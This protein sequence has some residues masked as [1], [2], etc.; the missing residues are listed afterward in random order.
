MYPIGLAS[1]GELG[2]YWE[3]PKSSLG[4]W[5]REREKKEQ[6][7]DYFSGCCVAGLKENSASF[8]YDY[9]TGLSSL[10]E[11]PATEQRATNQAVATTYSSSL[12]FEPIRYV[13]LDTNTTYTRANMYPKHSGSKLLK[14]ST[15][16]NSPSGSAFDAENKFDII[17]IFFDVSEF[18]SVEIFHMVCRL[19]IW[20]FMI[21]G[22]T[23]LEI[24][25]R[26]H[27]QTDTRTNFVSN[28]DR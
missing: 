20:S 10:R 14:V 5:K 13:Y 18:F 24:S 23:V 7:F 6:I 28:I 3:T 2:T 22:Q 11:N 25:V 19:R 9:H 27:I 16:L 17:E 8:R 12:S 1:V 26:T 4:F 15:I 21:L